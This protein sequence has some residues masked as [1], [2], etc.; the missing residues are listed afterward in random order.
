[1]GGHVG[2]QPSSSPGISVKDLMWSRKASRLCKRFLEPPQE[3][4]LFSPAWFSSVPPWSSLQ[5]YNKAPYQQSSVSQD[6]LQC[7]R[8]SKWEILNTGRISLTSC[9]SHILPSWECVCSFFTFIF[10]LFPELSVISDSL[11]Q[12]MK[13]AQVLSHDLTLVVWYM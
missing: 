12:W 5:I 2:H 10:M 7:A 13:L 6:I 9:L 8:E 4:S 3:R 1:M 11:L